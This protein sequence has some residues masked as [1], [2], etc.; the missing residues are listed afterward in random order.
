MNNHI[1]K[2]DDDGK[3]FHSH[4]YA[5]VAHGDQIGSTTSISFEQRQL[6]DRN[7]RIIDNYQ[8]STIGGKYGELRAKAVIN[9]DLN[10]SSIRQ[11]GALQQPGKIAGP[12][13][14]SEP[15]SR[16]FNPYA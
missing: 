14:F 12:R 5:V 16:T 7:R 4:G 6:I 9:K 10:R 8:R 11:R 13:R 1:V 3:P 15:Q 2:P